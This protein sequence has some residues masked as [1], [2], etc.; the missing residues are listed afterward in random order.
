MI[1]DT[2]LCTGLK[3][4]QTKTFVLLKATWWLVA[5]QRWST[6]ACVAD[7]TLAL[8]LQQELLPQ[9]QQQEQQQQ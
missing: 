2:A 3:T 8:V 5:L 7:V 9:Q 1:I 4:S 6:A